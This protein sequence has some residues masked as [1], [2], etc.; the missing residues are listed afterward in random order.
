VSTRRFLRQL[1]VVFRKELRDSS[2]DRRAILAIVIGVLV[3]PAVIGFMVNHLAERQR[4]AEQVRIPVVG[5]AHAP[6]FVGWLRMQWG[7]TVVDGPEDAERAVRD[8]K[9][10]VIL[11]ILP[12]FAERF[13]GSRAA[14]VSLVSDGS[15][16]SSTPQVARVRELL[17]RYS[18]EIAALRLIAHGVSPQV[19]TTLR[20]DEVEVSTAQ[21]RA[22]NILNFL[23]LFMLMSAL[24]GGVQLATDSTAGE[25]ERGSL[26]PLLV[27]PVP[28]GALVGGKW[29]A[30][31]AASLL[32]VV[33]SMGFCAGLLKL[34]LA[35]DIGVRIPIG[36]T[37]MGTILL[38]A[39]SVCPL[40]AALQ[41]FVGTYSRSFKEA[42]SY[43]GILMTLPVMAIA[44]VG[45]I[46]PLRNELWMYAIPLL[47]QY[48]M[49]TSAI[50]GT[51][52]DALAFAIATS[53]SLIAAGLLVAWTT[54][55]FRSE[56]IV[57][58]R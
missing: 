33:L 35:P 23:G 40:S 17:M 6:A 29:L 28:R 27:N 9:E 12:E 39:L 15:R 53:V 21:Q 43:I 57:F 52:P 37:Q 1:V 16:D 38:A 10:D 47:S 50:G 41:V 56:R 54:R 51:A 11:V 42:Q 32:A 2:R 58:G 36:A 7:V 14:P 25:R 13:G 30:A 20:V 44:V 22:A 24:T 48:T 19:V 18:S 4:Q 31:S 49:V 26:E 8:G 34:V 3:G 5:A 45:A 46:Y 55:L